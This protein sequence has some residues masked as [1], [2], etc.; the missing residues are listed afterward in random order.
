MRA[1]LIAL[2]RLWQRLPFRHLTHCR[3]VP[4]CSEYAV[5]AVETHGVLKGCALAAWRVLRCQPLCKAGFDPVPP[6]PEN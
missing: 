5:E 2:V 1:V 3:F 6:R 4:S